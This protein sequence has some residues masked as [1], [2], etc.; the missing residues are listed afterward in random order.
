MTNVPPLPP[1]EELVIL[2][3]ELGRLDARRSQ[4]LARR[5]WLLSV[6]HPPA[7]VSVGAAAPTAPP[8]ARRPP[9]ASSPSVQNV[10]L[11]LGG[12]L[13]AIAAIAFTLVSWGAMG[14]SG[15]SAVLGTVTVAAL[16]AP[17]ALLRR[18]LSS[19][20]EAVAALGLVLT[21]LDAYALHR[22]ALP[23]TDD[24]AYAAWASAVLAALW[25]GYG[26]LLGGLRL[27]LPVA[28]T[29]AQLPLVLWAATGRAD[30]IP[31]EWALLATAAFDVAVAVRAGHAGVRTIAAA[32][33]SVAGSGALLLGLLQ[34]AVAEAPSGTLR[35]AVLL[36]VAAGVAL[37][38]AWRAPSAAPVASV[39]AGLSLVAGVGGVVREVLPGGWAGPAYLLCALALLLAVRSP[40][41]RKTLPRRVPRGLAVA[42]ASVQVLAAVWA[43][44]ALV[45]TLAG[46]LTVLPEIWSGPPRG[47]REA[48]GLPGGPL[49]PAPVV[50]LTVAAVLALYARRAADGA[51]P[52]SAARDGAPAAPA[53]AAGVSGAPAPD[54]DRPVSPAPD[55]GASGAEVPGAPAAGRAE[56][57]APGGG[58]VGGWGTWAPPVS[59]PARLSAAAGRNAAGA[60]AFGLGWAA[61]TVLPIA[62]GFGYTASVVFHLL[63]TLGTLAL[64]T[65]PGW[66]AP[67]APAAAGAAL[68]CALTG[69]VSLGLLSLGTRPATFTVL[70]TL[71]AALTAVAVVSRA[72][73][74]VRGVTACAAVVF[75]T[76]LVIAVCG[77]AGLE[78]HRM[79][80]VL[81]VVPA[82]VAVVAARLGR[83]PLAVPLEGT[84]AVVGLS[85]VPFAV[86]HRPTLALVLALG[87]VIAAGTA[88][89]P[90]RRP[91]AGYAAAGLFLAATWVRLAASGVTA[92][93]AYTLPVTVLALAV[94]VLRRR[95]DAEV[96]SWTAYGP[97]LAATL[98]PSLHAAWGDA[99]WLRPLLL[100]LA[101]LA[102]TLAGARLRL[103][104]LLVLGGAVLALDALHEL[105]PYVV[106]VVGA[107]PRWLP[108]A[109]AGLLL[110]GVGATYEQRLRDARRL[111]ESV[112]RM[113]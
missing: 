8:G 15:R 68:G 88:I 74:A 46:P 41:V 38:A 77:A 67:H 53:P 11:V 76:W 73:N 48:L 99:H 82:V 18:R 13:L 6:L 42:S 50:L 44:P 96:P 21:V 107:L 112:G 49:A 19:T 98:V 100:G 57:S 71:V 36:V 78:S 29:A 83:S 26:T 56:P 59:R 24:A 70:A 66:A 101:A 7:G 12:V 104:A 54:K 17:V 86:E 91:G 60:V 62:A 58:P 16:A 92:P 51:S 47:A 61:L 31:L 43:L 110:L 64:I 33:A 40:S 45:L 3:R 4:L 28:M 22:V 93:E 5:A 94:G 79:G 37:F 20:A 87:G 30:S 32:G 102:V 89:R 108:P 85:A 10:L 25:A 23:G 105:A 2:D 81:L 75:G 97:G 72:G 103:Q 113:R 55:S 69:A 14:I 27:P 80:P 109:L 52:A 90:E 65:R 39:V 1:A 84:A 95:R 106:Q 63:L 34:S 9:E 35:P 111:R